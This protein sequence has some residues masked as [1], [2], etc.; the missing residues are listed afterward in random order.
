[1]GTKKQTPAFVLLF[2]II[3]MLFRG[4]GFL[5]TRFNWTATQIVVC[6]VT[7]SSVTLTWNW[8]KK[9]SLHQSFRA[10]GF[11]TPEWRAVGI[12]VTISVLTLAFFPIYSGLTG[13]KLPLQSNWLWILIGLVTGTGIDD[14][15]LFRGYAFNF[16]RQ[17]HGFW[18]AAT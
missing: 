18:K 12:A 15:T 17:T 13:I 4:I 16:F 14:E 9:A 10:V 2:V 1:M 3:F 11:G 7:I 6:V 5:S 8:L